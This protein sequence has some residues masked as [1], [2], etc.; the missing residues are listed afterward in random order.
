MADLVPG[1]IPGY[2]R[3]TEA[4]EVRLALESLGHARELGH[5]AASLW[6]GWQRS[7]CDLIEAAQ[8]LSGATTP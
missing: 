5:V 6:N 2:G 4:D 8:F 7:V 3:W 1:A